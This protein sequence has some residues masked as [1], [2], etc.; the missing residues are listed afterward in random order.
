M[1]T[2]SCRLVVARKMDFEEFAKTTAFRRVAHTV[3]ALSVQDERIA[4]EFRA[5]ERGRRASGKIVEIEGDVPV[6]LKI[7]L[8]DFA[9]TISTRI[10]EDV[11]RI[12]WMAFDEAR[13]TV[14]KLGLKSYNDWAS[15]CRSGQ[16]PP[17]IP[18]APWG[19][20]A[21]HGWVSLGD[22]LGTGRIADQKRKYWTFTK[23]R[24]FVHRLGL[25]STDDWRAY[26][27]SGQKPA[28][29]PALPRQTYANMGW[30][31]MGDWLGTGR[32]RGAG[33]QPF[34]K[35]RAYVRRLG[36]KSQAGWV[37]YCKSGKKPS[38]IPSSPEY[39]YAETGWAGMGDW[40]GTGTVAS[41]LLQFRSFKSA[42]GFARRL[43]LKSLSEWRDYCKSGKKP[44]DIPSTPDQ[45]YAQAGWSDFGD[46]LGTGRKRRGAAWRPFNKARS[47]VRRLGLKSVSEWQNYCTSGKRPPDIPA[48]PPLVYADAGWSGFG[49][50]LGTGSRRRGASWRP[51]NKA[52]SFARRLGLKSYKE[53]LDYNKSGKRP[54]DIPSNP[55]DTYAKAGWAGFPDWFGYA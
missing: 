24:A 28:D 21:K 42:R 43:G 7:K 9:K 13:S 31:G 51:F 14:R 10:W 54:D 5:I 46:W 39:I 35:A 12:N 18:S 20:Y 29:V 1:L 41:H 50:W 53:W 48:A 2:F 33:W 36:L 15:Y 22:W 47:F 32:L 19:V 34:K 25:K 27:A 11:G 16:K 30:T 45:T 6:G 52:R 8:G 17:D 4:D 40:L 55:N 38:D 49:D 23:A 3:A 44:A 26:C 37:R